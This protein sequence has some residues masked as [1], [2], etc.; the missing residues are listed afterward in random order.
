MW[1]PPYYAYLC[2]SKL[3]LWHKN[4]WFPYVRTMSY[5]LWI[6]L[7]WN[8]KVSGRKSTNY[9]GMLFDLHDV[10]MT[11]FIYLTQQWVQWHLNESTILANFKNL[12]TILVQNLS[13]VSVAL[14]H[15]FGTLSMS[16]SERKN[17]RNQ[18][19]R[20]IGQKCKLIYS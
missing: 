2:H 14:I 18:I 12:S 19:S 6:N 8:M 3:L 16:S 7:L 15:K 1:I 4:A 13:P 17:F 10:C 11:T 20:V 5:Q 9:N